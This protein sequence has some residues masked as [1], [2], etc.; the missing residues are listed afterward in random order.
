MVLEAVRVVHGGAG[1]GGKCGR[2][3]RGIEPGGPDDLLGR[4]PGDVLRHLGRES[5]HI[6][7]VFLEPLGPSAHELLIVEPLLDDHVGHAEG[8]CPGG[9]GPDA[10]V[11]IG[12][13]AVKGVIRG[14][15][16]MIFR[17]RSLAS[18]QLLT[19]EVLV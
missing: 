5:P 17:P 2:F 6:V 3:G 1:A 18:S 10:E 13:A 4:N 11:E 9:A 8:Q 7:P 19:M 15:T 12:H 14:P 16:S